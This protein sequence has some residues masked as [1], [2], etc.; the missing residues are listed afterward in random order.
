MAEPIK[1]VSRLEDASLGNSQAI[2][3]ARR[4]TSSERQ[5]MAV[6]RSMQRQ[7]RRAVRKGD[8]QT[9]S[10]LGSQ[11]SDMGLSRTGG[12]G[13]QDSQENNRIASDRAFNRADQL[14]QAAGRGGTAPE[15]QKG[16]PHPFAPNVGQGAADDIEAAAGAS[17]AVGARGTNGQTGTSTVSPNSRPAGTAFQRESKLLPE[18]N[19]APSS[20]G[21]KGVD[22]RSKFIADLD[23]SELFKEGDA[24]A[25][26][27]A[28]ARGDRFGITREQVLARQQGRDATLSG[29]AKEKEAIA[30]RE[31]EKDTDVV[32]GPEA[33][34]EDS[35]I[36]EATR[37][38]RAGNKAKELTN[39][40]I[41]STNKALEDRSPIE[42]YV[43]EPTIARA[44]KGTDVSGAPKAIV[45]QEEPVQSK[46]DWWNDSMESPESRVSRIKEGVKARN[47]EQIAFKKEY[48]QIGAGLIEEKVKSIQVP[49]WQKNTALGS[50]NRAAQEKLIRF[51]GV[52][53][54]MDERIRGIMA[55]NQALKKANERAAEIRNQAANLVPS[56]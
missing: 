23:K 22:N 34:P 48:D 18:N 46:P 21:I 1:P 43:P 20:A 37:I 3:E 2:A 55:R 28:V 49:E 25:I 31:E 44:T 24:G 26:E 33:P 52:G 13:I 19:P 54:E 27:R 6:E 5:S 42:D 4:A 32:M 41:A 38:Q 40:G 7:Y 8:M 51:N 12:G 45:V 53:I 35:L 56:Q 47:D 50:I 29:I 15:P 16:T 17:G 36:A 11:M 10:V 39:E 30:K 9:I 14:N